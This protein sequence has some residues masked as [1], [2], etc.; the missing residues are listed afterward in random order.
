MKCP[1][2]F[3]Q[4]SKV[5]DKRATAKGEIN[6]RRRVCSACKKRYTTYERVESIDVIIIK[7]DG[8]KEPYSREKVLSGILKS[9]EKRPISE[10]QIQKTVDEIERR[11]KSYK[12]NEI[13]SSVIGELVSKK[14]KALDKVAYI[15]FTSVYKS[16]A[17]AK[18]FEKEIKMLR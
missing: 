4:K 17:N 16:F 2:C 15:R 18:D 6:R 3:S 9:C 13:K 11:I 12:S 7:K 14:L 8:R 1:Y 5:V 10:A